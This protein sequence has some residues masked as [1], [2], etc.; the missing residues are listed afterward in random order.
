MKCECFGRIYIEKNSDL[1]KI[2]YTFQLESF[3]IVIVH[4]LLMFNDNVL[5]VVGDEEAVCPP[6]KPAVDTGALQEGYI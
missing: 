1:R 2:Y 4:E 6:F 3:L 5:L